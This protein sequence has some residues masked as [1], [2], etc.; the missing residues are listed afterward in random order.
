MP[1]FTFE[2]ILPPIPRGSVPAVEKKQ[3]S[4]I[5]Q[6]LD[7]FIEARVKRTLRKEKA[8]IVRRQQTPD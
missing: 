5:V 3:R 8:V 6:L 7:R 2:K 1:S 4:V